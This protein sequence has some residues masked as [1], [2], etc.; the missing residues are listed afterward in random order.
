MKEIHCF[1]L[2][3]DLLV[4]IFETKKNKVP[5]IPAEEFACNYLR[6]IDDPE[7]YFSTIPKENVMIISGVQLL[8]GKHNVHRGIIELAKYLPNPHGLGGIILQS[9]IKPDEIDFCPEL[10]ELIKHDSILMDYNKVFENVKELHKFNFT[11]VIKHKGYSEKDE[12]YSIL[13]ASDRP[14]EGNYSFDILDCCHECEYYKSD[15]EINKP[16]ENKLKKEKKTEEYKDYKL[17][18]VS[19]GS[20]SIDFLRASGLNDNKI[21]EEFENN[22]WND[23]PVLFLMENPSKDDENNPFYK[24]VGVENSKYPTNTWYWIHNKKRPIID[25]Q[26]D[27]ESYLK[28]GYYG[29]MVY[30]LVCKYKL[31]NAYLTNVIKCGMNKRT[32]KKDGSFEDGYIGTWW[33]HDDCKRTCI[34]SIL[35]QEIVKLTKGYDKLVVFAFGNNAYWLANDYFRTHDLDV[36]VRLF[37]L[38]HPAGRLSNDYRRYVLKGIISDA[39]DDNKQELGLIKKNTVSEEICRNIFIEKFNG[40]GEQ[41][42]KTTNENHLGLK[43]VTSKTVFN[44]ELLTEIILRGSSKQF[45]GKKEI[46]YYF[47]DDLYWAWDRDKKCRMECSE[48]KYFNEFQEC[49]DEIFLRMNNR[50]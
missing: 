29:E 41:I 8:S 37:K 24:K 38:P 42:K 18:Y 40:I 7:K 43:I 20:H 4:N 34:N 11:E 9:D 21:T 28:Q 1:D 3:V 6:Y 15:N 46:G 19:H 23:T 12:P 35:N 5:V 13:N 49:I 44:E 47:P 22:N 48:F 10:T 36:T 39:L 33:Y 50:E 26:S 2:N 25:M 27:F 16:D 45:G 31:A 30:A 32:T 14:E 17:C